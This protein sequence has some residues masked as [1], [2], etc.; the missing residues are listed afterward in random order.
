MGVVWEWGSHFWGSLE[1]PLIVWT[2]EL[3]TDSDIRK[4]SFRTNLSARHLWVSPHTVPWDDTWAHSKTRESSQFWEY[5]QLEKGLV[6][7]RLSDIDDLPCFT[8]LVHQVHVLCCCHLS[9]QLRFKRSC[10]L[11]RRIAQAI[12]AR[13]KSILR[14]SFQSMFQ[15]FTDT[16]DHPTS[17]EVIYTKRLLQPKKSSSH[18]FINK[19]PPC[20]ILIYLSLPN[21][22]HLH[23][24]GPSESH[25]PFPPRTPTR[26]AILET[27]I[28]DGFASL[29][30]Q[31]S[32]KK[33]A[34]MGLQ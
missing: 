9:I 29:S 7:E 15:C 33:N 34:E 26:E 14:F 5:I 21:L 23:W 24:M 31:G 17:W 4:Q 30:S 13:Q 12:M 1:F 28:L 18:K 22:A 27:M 10:M 20:F 3:W 32:P 8:S 25:F 2:Q 11:G 19:Q 16:Q 6:V